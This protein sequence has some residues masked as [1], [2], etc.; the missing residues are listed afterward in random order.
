M[1]CCIR[2]VE[3]RTMTLLK[4]HF[5]MKE[6]GPVRGYNAG[7]SL[8]GPP[9]M[10]AWCYRL[11]EVLIDTGIR[12]LRKALVQSQEANPPELILV[13]HHHED[14][15][16]NAGEFQRRFGTRVLGHP[17]TAAILKYPFRIR[18]YQHLVWGKSAPVAVTPYPEL[19]DID[20]FRIRPV[21]TPGHSHDHTVYLEET[22]GLL[23]SGDLFLGERIKFFRADECLEDQIRSLRHVLT[24]S[25]DT[26]FCAHRPTLTGGKKAMAAKLDFLVDFYGNVK[27]RYDQGQ[28]FRTILRTLDPKNDRM[29]KYITLNNACFAHMVRSA[30]SLAE[31][32]RAFGPIV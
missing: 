8:A 7:V 11:G 28:D 5:H 23:F 26:L 14:H 4:K 9:I 31:R 25:F 1:T 17:D 15:S 6:F 18:P 22:Q 20:G 3:N 30:L 13:T 12:H 10:T 19:I 29:V 32:E 16:G 27:D 2:S 24:L 21:H